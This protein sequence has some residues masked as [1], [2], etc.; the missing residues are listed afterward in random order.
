MKAGLRG[1]L[2]IALSAAL[3]VWTLHGIPMTQVIEV[4]K[5]SNWFLL[6]ASTVA[7]TSIFPRR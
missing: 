3:L 6:L 4:L 1:A 7:A 2:G 5:N